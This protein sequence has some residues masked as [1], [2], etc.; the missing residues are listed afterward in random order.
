M[1]KRDML[2]RRMAEMKQAEARSEE[3]T[4]VDEILND[5]EN[6]ENK[7][8]E[9]TAVPVIQDTPMK[10]QEF[11]PR[12]DLIN[13]IDKSHVGRPKTLKGTYKPI[14]ARLKMENYVFARNEGG[15]YGGMNAYIN[16]LIEKDLKR[17]SK[18]K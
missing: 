10:S 7:A 9:E 13:V 5:F 6:G 17:K 3:N 8:T 4:I 16:Y 15:K 1:S 11:T 12:S 2:A 18:N 14:S